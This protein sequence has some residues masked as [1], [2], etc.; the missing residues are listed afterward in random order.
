M[1]QTFSDYPELLFMD[2]TCKLSDV[3]MPLYLLLVVDRKGE[4]VVSFL[5]SDK[6]KETISMMVQAFKECNTSWKNVKAIM[7]NKDLVERS[8]MRAKFPKASLFI[9]LFHVLCA[10]WCEVTCE[11]MSRRPPQLDLCLEILQKIVYS[12]STVEYE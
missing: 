4:I 5:V 8:A 10:F 1:Q 2:A 3:R 11:P 7:S 6:T 12:Q 9:C